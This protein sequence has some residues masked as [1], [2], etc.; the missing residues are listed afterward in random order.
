MG[1]Y[2]SFGDTK[3]VPLIEKEHL[4]NLIVASKAYQLDSALIKQLWEA[5]SDAIY[6]LSP[7]DRQLGFPPEVGIVLIN[8]IIFSIN[9]FFQGIT[10]YYSAN[11][12]HEDAAL[13]QEFMLQK[14]CPIYFY[15]MVTKR[16]SHCC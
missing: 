13:V 4:H 6:S 16:Y 9:L 7:G 14:V 11:C 10:A 3:L 2:R 1:N 12:T 5:V 8:L 15:C